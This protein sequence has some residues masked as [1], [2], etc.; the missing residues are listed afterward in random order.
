MILDLLTAGVAGQREGWA[1]QPAH[2]TERHG[3]FIIVALAEAL[4]AAGTVATGTAEA[5]WPG[6]MIAVTILAVAVACGL[7]WTY[8]F[9][10]HPTLEMR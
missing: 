6:E 4:I 9:Q 8:F 2:F 5:H 7:W 1:L 3:L 10:G